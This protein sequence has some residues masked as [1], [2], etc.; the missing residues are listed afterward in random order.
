ML[1]L[2][3][4]NV[5]PGKGETGMKFARKAIAAAMVLLVATPA[6]AT[7]E[8]NVATFLAKADALKAKGMGALFSPDMKLLKSEGQAAGQAYR[9]RL[10]TERAAGHP[11]SCPPQGARVSSD[12]LLAFLRTYPEAQRPRVTMNAAMA[13]FFI[14]KWPC[15]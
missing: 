4:R 8:M 5:A 10:T 9:Q 6:F 3:A 2:S 12:D 13:D 7:G 1:N 15:H 14:R 11:S